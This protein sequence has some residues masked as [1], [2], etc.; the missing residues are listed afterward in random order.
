MTMETE[1]SGWAV[2]WTFFAAAMMMVIGVYHGI[3]GLVGLFEDELLVT[4][5][6]YILELDVTTWGWIHLILGIVVF[7]A[8]LALLSGATWARVVGVTIAILS[9]IANFAWLPWYPLWAI[10]MI[11]VSVFVIWA[12][13]VHG[14]DITMR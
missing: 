9:M 1:T 14:R 13:T 6:Q 2:G 10:V 7:V 4:A 12:L 3:A 5:G 11:A 8:G